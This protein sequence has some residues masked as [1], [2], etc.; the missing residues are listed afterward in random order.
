[1]HALISIVIVNW[2]AGDLLERCVASVLTQTLPPLEVIVVD[3]G[4][5]DGSARHIGEKFNSV[6]VI[7]AGE[8]IGFAA[9]NNLAVRNV[10]RKCSWIVLL[11]PDAFP[12]PTWLES[13]FDA[14]QRNLEY[15]FFGCRLMDAINPLIVDGTGDTYHSSGLVWRAGHGK[16]FNSP[17]VEFKE[18]FSPCAAAAMYR[19][20]V[21]L[22]AGGFDEDFFCYVEDVDLGF[23]LRLLGHRCLYVP[24]SVVYHVGSAVTGRRSDFSVYHGHRNL[25]WTFTKNVPGFLFWVLLPLHLALNIVTVIYFALHGQ[26]SVIWRAKRDAI[27][28]IPKMWRKRRR[29]QSTR[30]ATPREIWRLMYK[31]LIPAKQGRIGRH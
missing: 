15:A 31:G 5:S 4:S 6:S 21:F 27:K 25:V 11:N 9:A 19:K 2:N 26:S 14:A 16:S 3:N 24:G 30:V 23:R 12:E 13:L 8:N 7:H 28:G 22:E 18:I 1:M 17:V 20:D 29:I 10:S